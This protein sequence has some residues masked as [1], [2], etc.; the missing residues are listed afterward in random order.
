MTALRSTSGHLLWRTHVSGRILA[1]PLVV[2]DLVFFSTL[3][4][5]TYGARTTDGKIVWTFAAGKYSPGIATNRH[6]YF[7][8]NGLL[9][10][11]DGTP[12]R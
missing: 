5:K 3:S 11:F 12:R 4:G 8:L 10:D 6:Y 7:S 9:V 1:P 2:G